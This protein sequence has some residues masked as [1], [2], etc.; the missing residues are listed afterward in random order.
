MASP[1]GSDDRR[2]L[3]AGKLPFQLRRVGG[4]GRLTLAGETV[5]GWVHVD[6]LEL[7]V[8]EQAG[9]GFD[10][11]APAE[12]YQRRRTQLVVAAL[13]VDQRAIEALT[14]ADRIAA[15]LPAGEAVDS[16]LGYCEQKHHVHRSQ[17]LT[18]LTD[19]A[20]ARESQQAG[21]ALSSTSGMTRTLLLLDGAMCD[22]RDGDPVTACEA[23]IAAFQQAPGR[24]RAG[25]V[26]Q[27]AMDLY[28][29]VPTTERRAAPARQ[30]A[31]LLADAA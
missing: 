5:L 17:A 1:T 7:E 23:A 8:P 12:R 14:A 3:G 27:R 4:G 18:A 24:F 10:A 31:D 22:R 21:I 25:L 9:Q 30:L 13:R 19:T 2:Q 15:K 11:A 29:S 20:A 26:R 6:R 28:A 16:W